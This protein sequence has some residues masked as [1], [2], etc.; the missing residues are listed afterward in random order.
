MLPTVPAWSAE[1]NQP[2]AAFGSS[3]AA[4]GDVNGDGFGDV[5]IGAPLYDG[6][7][8]DE[9][10][11]RIFGGAIT[12][13]GASPLQSLESNVAGTRFGFAV[14]GG[15]DMNGGGVRQILYGAPT[16]TYTHPEEGGTFLGTLGQSHF[17][18]DF[19][20]QDFAHRGA[21]IA[22]AGDV[23][24]DGLMDVV[25]GAD[26]FDA[27]EEDEGRV[28]VHLGHSGFIVDRSPA[29]VA[30][31]NQPF[32]AF[33][34][35]VASAGDVNGDGYGDVV[36]GAPLFDRGQNDEGAV[37]VYLGPSGTVTA[38]EA[39]SP[40]AGLS[41]IRVFPSPSSETAFVQADRVITYRG[42]L[43]ARLYDLQGR[44]VRAHTVGPASQG[45]V[46]ASIPTMDL[47]TGVYFVK[48]MGENGVAVGPARR[49]VVVR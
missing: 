47:A 4:L 7:Q 10:Q 38:V 36:V 14:A 28:T 1:G 9:G 32:S 16:Y 27:G 31:G 49:L 12:G 20:R 37:F 22:S 34:S 5:V 15:G 8:V 26:L 6:G 24:A 35:S 43:E 23:N 29:W 18:L 13:L 39:E 17:F 33:G 46:R 45:F 40:A 2:G 21:S 48:L 25:I 44:L 3:V 42:I 41:G 11:V 30:D 19:G